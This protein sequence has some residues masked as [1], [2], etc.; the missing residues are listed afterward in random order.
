MPKKFEM[1]FTQ[2]L[3]AAQTK[4]NVNIIISH[5]V[6]ENNRAELLFVCLG[7]CLQKSLIWN[8]CFAN[9]R[10]PTIIPELKTTDDKQRECDSSENCLNNEW[11]GCVLV[12]VHNLT[13]FVFRSVNK[14]GY[15]FWRNT[16]F[17]VWLTSVLCQ[18]LLFLST[19]VVLTP[20]SAFYFEFATSF[21]C[22]NMI[23]CRRRLTFRNFLSKKLYHNGEWNKSKWETM[24]QKSVWL[25]RLKAF[26]STCYRCGVMVRTVD[27][28]DVCPIISVDCTVNRMAI[29]Y[30]RLS[31]I[32]RIL[33][34][35]ESQFTHIKPKI[36][37]LEMINIQ[38]Q[39]QSYVNYYINDKITV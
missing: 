32:S 21:E 3:N 26:C 22:E 16:Q 39:I 8:V 25:Q 4:R 31:A 18:F 9:L 37:E 38:R 24:C 6:G 17:A 12:W 36:A 5:S 29:V 35:Y 7:F 10:L 13:I 33:W 1:Y 27:W 11:C 20:W 19:I 23:S 15:L 2:L 34:I 14:I 28:N 30:Q